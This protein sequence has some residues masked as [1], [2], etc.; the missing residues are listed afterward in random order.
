ML[1]DDYAATGTG[2]TDRTIHGREL[3]FNRESGDTASDQHEAWLAALLERSAELYATWKDFSM[4]GSVPEITT[5]P[6]LD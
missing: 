4:P 3:S 2:D 6:S 1:R 5:F